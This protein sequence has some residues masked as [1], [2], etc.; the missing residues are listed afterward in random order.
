MVV[1]WPAYGRMASLASLWWS[2]E[3]RE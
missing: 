1:E 3:L 2:D